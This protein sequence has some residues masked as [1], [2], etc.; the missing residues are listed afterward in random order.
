MRQWGSDA[1]LA[2]E[3]LVGEHLVGERSEELATSVVAREVGASCARGGLAGLR[4]E[5]CVAEMKTRRY[6]FGLF[7]DNKMTPSY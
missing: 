5:K 3:H 1:H 6:D 7:C 4:V 2:G